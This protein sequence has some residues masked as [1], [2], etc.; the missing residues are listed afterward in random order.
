MITPAN[1]KSSRVVDGFPT[2][3]RVVRVP[4]AP[5]ESYRAQLHEAEWHA[6]ASLDGHRRTEHVAGRVAAR[7][8]IA[9]LLGRA[10]DH[11]V[12]SRAE[13]GAPIVSGIVNPPLV[14]I[15][16]G[17]SAAV[18]IAAHASCLGIDLCE[19]EDAARVRNVLARF[20]ALEEMGLVAHASSAGW[21]TLWALKEAAAKAVR[22]GLL[23][24][25]L[26]AT[27]VAS[28]EPPAFAWPALDAA[29]VAGAGDV[30]AV[31]YKA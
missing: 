28:I 21:A 15:S 19:H 10:A 11:A 1:G 13:D 3:L 30:I 22:I 7:A 16:H 29:V 26:R 27:R 24:G 9:A 8:A 6:A 4:L 12:V 17:R 25:G 14:S 2:A 5:A 23:D 18:A 20:A 31:A